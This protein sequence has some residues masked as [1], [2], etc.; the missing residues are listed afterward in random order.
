MAS[1]EYVE[2]EEVASSA[3][4]EKDRESSLTDVFKLMGGK[5]WDQALELIKTKT[6]QE[7]LELRNGEDWTV[8]HV[9]ASCGEF[10]IAEYCLEELKVDVDVLDGQDA[11]PLYRAIGFGQMD[12]ID[13]LVEQGANMGAI[14]CNTDNMLHNSA[15]AGDEKTSLRL[16]G[17][18]DPFLQDKWNGMPIMDLITKLPT[19]ASKVFDS[20]VTCTYRHVKN[21][22][23]KFDF[24]G[25]ERGQELKDA[26]TPIELMVKNEVADLLEHPLIEAWFQVR[27]ESFA[28]GQLFRQ[29]VVYTFDLGVLTSFAVLLKKSDSFDDGTGGQL[30]PIPILVL[31]AL[32]LLECLRNLIQEMFEFKGG[33]MQ[34]VHL[35][36]FK[37]PKM[38]NSYFLDF[39]NWADVLT[40]VCG[41]S[42]SVLTIYRTSTYLKGQIEEKDVYDSG[43]PTSIL[44]I[45]L[46]LF[47]SKSLK[48]IGVFRATG[49][50][51]R[52]I[53]RMTKDLV[54]FFSFFLVFWVGFSVAWFVK[55]KMKPKEDLSLAL[56]EAHK[57]VLHTTVLGDPGALDDAVDDL[58][59]Q[60]LFIAMLLL[61]PLMLANLL[62]AMMSNSY[63]LVQTRVSA[64]WRMV[65]VR[66]ILDCDRDIS[67]AKRNQLL[68][69]AGVKGLMTPP[70]ENYTDFD[71]NEAK[72]GA[73]FD[74]ETWY[75]WVDAS[76][77]TDEEATININLVRDELLKEM[78]RNK[79]EMLTEMKTMILMMGSSSP[80]GSPLRGRSPT[81]R[82]T[83]SSARRGTL[84]KPAAGSLQRAATK[85]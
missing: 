84:S 43:F 35:S 38:V 10:D 56:W 82:G 37:R 55:R 40:Y 76:Q 59:S 9:A 78:K 44:M 69:E 60:T 36:C 33:K 11:T 61:M 45:A 19:V 63:G 2:L 4:E 52:I 13:Y 48:L 72:E 20:K 66:F 30:Y 31:G 17:H 80:G 26:L 29:I 42:T 54:V 62:I 8:L 79:E 7:F 70:A 50:Y 58:V 74:F 64:E 32:L 47:W 18:C 16:L 51:V 24:S 5:K 41:L 77:D 71:V 22:L 83:L 14:N 25:L 27:W 1:D 12:M 23:M 75:N 53:I 34:S 39:W 46:V 15:Y 49:P 57:L 73:S 6:K 65:W 85:M 21:R 67:T 28:R 3:P 68:K 81:R